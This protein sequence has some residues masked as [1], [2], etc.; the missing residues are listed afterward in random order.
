MILYS[1]HRSKFVAVVGHSWIG[2]GCDEG[3][4]ECYLPWMVGCVLVELLFD[5]RP[6]YYCVAVAENSVM[7]ELRS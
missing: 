4:G 6:Y 1:C 5:D 3:G 7:Y 2:G